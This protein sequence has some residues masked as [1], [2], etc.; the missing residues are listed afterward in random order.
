VFWVSIR[1][2]DDERPLGIPDNPN[3]DNNL[4]IIIRSE[5]TNP[6][7]AQVHGGVPTNVVL[8]SVLTYIQGSSGYGTSARSSN[9]IDL[10]GGAGGR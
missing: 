2:D 9:S 5:C 4:V 3:R 7:W 8:E 1:D 6:T 10:A